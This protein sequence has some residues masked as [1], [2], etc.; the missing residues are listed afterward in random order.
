MKKLRKIT[1]FV[2]SMMALFMIIGIVLICFYPETIWVKMSFSIGIS[3]VILALILRYRLNRKRSIIFSC[4]DY[5]FK[6]HESKFNELM[7]FLKKYNLS[8]DLID[9]IKE[10]RF[11]GKYNTIYIEKESYD[12]IRGLMQDFQIKTIGNKK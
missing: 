5:M 6:L 3:L 10:D 11:L 12:K 7:N 8:H 4:P 1:D 9:A 2:E